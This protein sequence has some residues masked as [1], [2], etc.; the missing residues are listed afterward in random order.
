MKAITMPAMA[1]ALVSCGE[2]HE[3]RGERLAAS[4][5]EAKA[6]ADLYEQRLRDAGVE[7]GSAETRGP[8]TD[9]RM[10][11]AEFEALKPG[12]T[13]AEATE[14][15]GGPGDLASESEVAGIHTVM[16]QYEGFGDVGAN[17]NVMFQD[18][19]LVQKAQFGLK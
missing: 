16:Y 17:A 18:G 5:A 19:K 7:V 14:I 8:S 2:S 4:A 10:S 12:M 9:P 3:E 6:T 15:I 11:K 1:L 13:Y